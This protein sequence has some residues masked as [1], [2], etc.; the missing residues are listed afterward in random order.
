MHEELNYYGNN[1]L[2]YIHPPNQLNRYETFLHFNN[3]Y[4]NKNFSII[5]SIFYGTYET[6]VNCLECKSNSYNFQKI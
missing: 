3:T 6:I 1:F 4:N 2:P 5:S